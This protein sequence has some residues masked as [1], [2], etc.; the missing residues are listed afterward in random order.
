MGSRE[1]ICGAASGGEAEIVCAGEGDA[2]IVIETEHFW[3]TRKAYIINC[4]EKM[5]Q[6]NPSVLF[7]VLGS[8][9]LGRRD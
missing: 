9:S 4:Q 8:Q 7:T 2:T 3:D 5:S 1:W 6:E